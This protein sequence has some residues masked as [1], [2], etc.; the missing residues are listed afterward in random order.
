MYS[1]SIKHDLV[2]NLLRGQHALVHFPETVVRRSR[3]ASKVLIKSHMQKDQMSLQHCAA[4]RTNEGQMND[5][6][7]LGSS[8]VEVSQSSDK[9]AI[10][11]IVIFG[12]RPA[13]A[14][15]CIQYMHCNECQLRE[16]DLIVII[17][18]H[19]VQFQSVVSRVSFSIQT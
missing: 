16:V 8:L 12:R 14:S 15:A 7:L 11:M 10:F 6:G 4:T 2:S 13:A 5:L 3:A 18:S 19:V 17:N 9:S 1:R